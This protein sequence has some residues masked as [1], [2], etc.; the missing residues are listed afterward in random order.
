MSG[1]GRKKASTG[2]RST[3]ISLTNVVLKRS[4]GLGIN[5]IVVRKMKR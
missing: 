5:E 4:V 2:I 3:G 1:G